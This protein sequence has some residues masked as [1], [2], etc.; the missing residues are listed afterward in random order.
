M[1][2][3]RAPTTRT[4]VAAHPQHTEKRLTAVRL[5]RHHHRH[6]RRFS[7][8]PRRVPKASRDIR[9]LTSYDGGSLLIMKKYKLLGDYYLCPYFLKNPFSKATM[10]VCSP[11]LVVAAAYRNKIVSFRPGVDRAW[12]VLPFGDDALYEDIALYRGKIY[13]LTKE[14]LLVHEIRDDNTLSPRAEHVYCYFRAGHLTTYGALGDRL[15]NQIQ[16]V[17]LVGG[18]CWS[19]LPTDLAGEICFRAVCRQWRLSALRHKPLPPAMPWLLAVTGPPVY[20][21]LADGVVHPID[22]SNR[23]IESFL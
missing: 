20:Q 11:E 2:P 4:A 5:R 23:V 8:A 13:A 17:D 6:R 15:L 12:L 1:A 22:E 10:L 19:D 16:G 18:K 9:C 21:D 3:R 7:P 14:D